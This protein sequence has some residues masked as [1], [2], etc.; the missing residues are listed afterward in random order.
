MPRSS[1]SMSFLPFRGDLRSSHICAALRALLVI[2]WGVLRTFSTG[3]TDERA[4][5]AAGAASLERTLQIVATIFQ[6]P[7]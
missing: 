6:N 2:L 7:R 3:H 5:E 1:R 4:R